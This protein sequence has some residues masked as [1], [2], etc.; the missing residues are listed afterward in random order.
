ML[1][2]DIRLVLFNF[3]T[4]TENVKRKTRFTALVRIDPKTLDWLKENKDTKTIAGFLDKIINEHKKS[5]DNQ[6]TYQ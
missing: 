1:Q 3:I 2:K 4:M 5:V 6:T